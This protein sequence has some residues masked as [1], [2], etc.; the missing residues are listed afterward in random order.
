MQTD[1]V[2]ATPGKLLSYLNLGILKL[3][4]LKHLI[5]DEADRMLDMGFYDDLL[6]ILAFLPRVRQNLLFSATMPS[7][8]RKL[9]KKILHRPV[10]V[11]VA[12]SKPAEGVLEAAYFIPPQKKIPLIRQLLQGKELQ[13]VL[14]FTS[15]KRIA[16]QLENELKSIGFS[17]KAIHSDL[18]QPQRDEVMRQFRNRNIQLLVATDLLSR[19]I[20]I[21]GIDLVVNFNVPR[22]PEDYI[23]RVGRTARAKASGVAITLVEPEE[24]RYFTR[25]EHFLEKDIY[26]IP[27][28]RDL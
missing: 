28:P 21:V 18:T 26:K 25:I 10:E 16:S 12:P 3:N 4:N 1:I 23:H 19:G 13:T 17:A 6:Q 2:V 27:V 7:D 9:A 8:I 11:N 15:T 20:D 22:D 14:M 5:L 24:K